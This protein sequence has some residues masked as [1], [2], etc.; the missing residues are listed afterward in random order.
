VKLKWKTIPG[1]GFH[2]RESTIALSQSPHA[3]A[4]PF[5]S[6]YTLVVKKKHEWNPMA[7]EEWMEKHRDMEGERGKGDGLQYWR[8]PRTHEPVPTAWKLTWWGS[9]GTLDTNGPWAQEYTQEIFTN[10]W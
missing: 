2:D 9:E 4:P 7:G 6:P 3:E 8:K 5:E 10:F 1:R